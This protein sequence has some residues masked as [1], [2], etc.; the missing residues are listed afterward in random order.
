MGFLK[1]NMITRIQIRSKNNVPKG[2]PPEKFKSS[3]LAIEQNYS[4]CMCSVI[5]NLL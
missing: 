1:I 5:G 3:E 4:A 2:M